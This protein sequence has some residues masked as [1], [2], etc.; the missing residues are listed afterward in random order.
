MYN[1]SICIGLEQIPQSQFGPRPN[2]ARTQISNLLY[3]ESGMP[4][5]N[6]VSWAGFHAS[7]VASQTIVEQLILLV[8]K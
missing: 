6:S 8:S 2:S 3:H 5:T 4:L 7:M 1:Y